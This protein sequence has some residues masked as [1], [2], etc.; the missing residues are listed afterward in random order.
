MCS[1]EHPDGRSQEQ[2]EGAGEDCEGERRQGTSIIIITIATTSS[3][4]RSHH[5]LYL[6]LH[7]PHHPDHH[8]DSTTT[9]A[10]ARVILIIMPDHWLCTVIRLTTSE[11]R[12]PERKLP[13]VHK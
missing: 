7:P 13:E 10:T 6:H 12:C 3:S 9:G 1:I 5:Y 2:P 4:S 11:K 8:Y